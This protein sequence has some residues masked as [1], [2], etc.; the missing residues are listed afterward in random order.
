MAREI[1]NIGAVPNDN[2]GDPLRE[3]FQ[4]L[5][6][7]TAELY[8]DDAG[9][10]DSVNGQTGVVVLDSDDIAEGSTNEYYT[11]AKVS[12]NTSVVANTNKVGITSAQ[13]SEI[14][15]NT[16]KTGITSSQAN[17]ITA[18]TAK[19]GITAQQAADIVTNNAKN[20]DQ[21]V[22]LTEGQNVTITG[23]YPNFTIASEDVVGAVNSVNGEAGTVVLDTGDISEN[24]N[25]YFT[26]AR[27]AANSAVT[28][29]TAK[30]GI[31]TQQASDITANNA[32]V[33]DQTV[34]LSEGANVTITGTYPNFTI[35]S[36]DVVGAVN[37]VNGDTGVVVL[38][39][40]DIG[41]SAT[42]NKFTTA[43]EI[44]KLAG[45]EAGA[46]VT[47]T[48]NVT[49]AGALMDSE[50]TN[51]SQVKAFDSSDYLASSVTTI[52]TQQAS[53]ITT[54]NAKTGITSGQASAIVANTAK[55]GITS[56]QASAITANTAK[57]G[58]T[59]S[60]A[61]AITANTAKVTNATHT[62][63]VAGSG[64][65]TIQTN[66]VTTAKI[67]NGNVTL[68][69]MAS[70]SVDSNQY[71]DGSIDTIHIANNNI[72]H[73]KLEN[74]YTAAVT[75]STL[76]GTYSLNWSSGAVF[77]MSGTLTGNINF[78]FSNMKIGQ[79]I[80]IYNLTG[81]RTVTFSTA[82]GTPVFNKAGGVD[83]DGASTN[84]IQ[85]QCVSDASNAVFNYAVSTYSSDSTPS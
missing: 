1:I 10:V 13:A 11:E 59:S 80:D 37:S 60:Q 7:M 39:A 27:V 67:L 24:G 8:S 21:T 2:S 68:A 50:V 56:G 15:A 84:L 33:S 40:D 79:V 46:D 26:D 25:L 48:T 28:A 61:S 20:T 70:N 18:N 58:I 35:A 82:S 5:N 16:A 12:A 4:K 45:I 85:V 47:D 72:T 76:T 63:D 38:D 78:Q 41:D 29:N 55:T 6:N 57:T 19:T 53:D 65:L 43:A 77:V 23:T 83:Y 17:A 74:R 62:G 9:D 3:A 42:T 49:A 31:T 44:S 81:V 52:T 36:D 34:T 22:T 30:T 71:V 64:V 54:N 51:L 73:D 14:S 75:V 32:K 66:A 69:K